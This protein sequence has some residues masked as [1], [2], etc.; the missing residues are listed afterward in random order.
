MTEPVSLETAKV[1]CE[2][3]AEETEWD[4]LIGGYI[5][6]ARSFVERYTGHIIVQRTLTEAFDRFP[7]HDR[8]IQIWKTPI[9]SLDE[10]RY[11][12][13]DEV[14]QVYAGAVERLGGVPA[15]IYPAAADRCW[16]S[17]SCRGGVTVDLTAGYDAGEEPPEAIQAMLLLI[18]HWFENRGAAVTGTIVGTLPMGVEALLD[19]IRLPMV[20]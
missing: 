16:P 15:K 13:W 4:E 14:E 3:D 17:A 12:D 7:F 8:A 20:G 19:S 18:A 10:L 2:V 1:Q 9:V 11:F 5:T 6:T